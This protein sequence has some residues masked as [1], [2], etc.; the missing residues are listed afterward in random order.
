MIDTRDV[1][2]LVGLVLLGAGLYFVYWP[3]ALIVP[4]AALV[5]KSLFPRGN[6][7][8]DKPNPPYSSGIE[9]R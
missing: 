1:I 2:A 9:K 8:E 7:D 5:W 4:G 6:H 3:A